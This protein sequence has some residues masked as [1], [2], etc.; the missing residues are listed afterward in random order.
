MKCSEAI[1][2]LDEELVIISETGDQDFHDALNLAIGCLKFRLKM[3]NGWAFST[4][5]KLSNETPES[6][7]PLTR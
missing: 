7:P 1:K 4:Y 2:K 6:E 5:E 3:N